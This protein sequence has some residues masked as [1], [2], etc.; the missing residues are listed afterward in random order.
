MKEKLRNK[1]GKSPQKRKEHGFQTIT[2]MFRKQQ[3]ATEVSK[4]EVIS[5]SDTN[6]KEE[7]EDIQI[8]FVETTSSYFLSKEKTSK[9]VKRLSLRKNRVKEDNKTLDSPSNSTLGSNA[10]LNEMRTISTDQIHSKIKENNRIECEKSYK[11]EKVEVPLSSSNTDG[12][13][14]TK[15]SL[16]KRKSEC[17]SKE[18]SL[19]E[20]RF[21]T[22]EE[23]K[24]DISEIKRKKSVPNVGP[25]QSGRTETKGNNGETDEDQTNNSKTSTPLPKDNS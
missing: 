8:T 16:R 9:S 11:T 6:S 18:T 13:S 21:R 15:L 17:P 10:D 20:K 7:E 1:K 24:E 23:K 12:N 3:L 19:V 2:S 4:S 22:V 25:L 5:T 14:K